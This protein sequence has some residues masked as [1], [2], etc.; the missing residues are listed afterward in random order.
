TIAGTRR[1]VDSGNTWRSIVR[2]AAAPGTKRL[3]NLWDDNEAAR[4]TDPLRVL[5]YRS[6]LLGADLR[7]TNVGGGN[8]SAKFDLPDPLTGEPACV[9]AVKGSGGDLGSID[10]T[11][12]A[13][14]RLGALECLVPRYHGVAH[15]DEMV[16]LYPLCAF[17]GNSV[18]ASIDTPLHAFLP[19]A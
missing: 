8:T 14:L 12:F 19:F 2:E 5:R 17:G 10:E 6:N 13:V 9:R 7:I 4:L 16:A 15:E 11:G 3:E 18:P 1:T